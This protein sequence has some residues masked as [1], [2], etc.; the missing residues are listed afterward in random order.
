[1]SGYQ[2]LTDLAVSDNGDH[3]DLAVPMDHGTVH[4]TMELTKA[5]KLARL[6]FQAAVRQMVRGAR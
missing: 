6:L 1:M 5:L 4:I 2:R 3:V